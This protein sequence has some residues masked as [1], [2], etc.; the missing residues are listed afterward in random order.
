[1]GD[2]IARGEGTCLVRG[3]PTRWAYFVAAPGFGPAR[4]VGIAASGL[5]VVVA[6]LPD[7]RRVSDRLQNLLRQTTF[8]GAGVRDFVAAAHLTAG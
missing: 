2:Y 1:V 3:A 7:S 6:V 8:G 4:E 5:Y